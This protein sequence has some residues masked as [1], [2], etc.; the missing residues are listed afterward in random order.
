MQPITVW[1]PVILDHREG[2]SDGNE[3]NIEEVTENFILMKCHLG[4]LNKVRKKIQ[5][6]PLNGRSP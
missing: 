1:M 6:I 2:A 5:K 3:K 4:I